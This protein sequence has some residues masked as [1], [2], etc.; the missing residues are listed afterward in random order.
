MSLL[1]LAAVM[2]LPTYKETE[3]G[4]EAQWAVNYLSHFL[5]I[6]LLLPLLEAGGQS[7]DSSRII[8]V[9]S[10]LHYIGNMNFDCINNYYK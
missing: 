3:D 6:S 4:F 10:C 9:S 2:N 1:F 7:G 8:N 5:L